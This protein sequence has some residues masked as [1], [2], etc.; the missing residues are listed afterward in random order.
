MW[1]A[2]LVE[3]SVAYSV[4]MSENDLVVQ[5]VDQKAAYLVCQSVV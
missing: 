2:H 3:R 1:G 5:K 4:E